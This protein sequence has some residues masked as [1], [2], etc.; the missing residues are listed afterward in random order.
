MNFV[1]GAVVRRGLV[2]DGKED[3]VAG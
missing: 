1:E 2:E 3:A